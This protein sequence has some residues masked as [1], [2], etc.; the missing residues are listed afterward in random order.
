[1]K[2]SF[3][4]HTIDPE[5]IADL[6]RECATDI[7]MPLYEKGIEKADIFEKTS[8]YDIATTADRE[9]EERLKDELP[10]LYK[11]SVV[12]G[13]E[14]VHDHPETLD[15]LNSDE[16]VIWVVDPVDGTANFAKGGRHF[17][18][19]MAC[20][21]NG[22][23]QFG[24]IYDV[25]DDEMTIAERGQGA[26]RGG[27][28][29]ATQQ[30][31]KPLEDLNGF[32][33]MRHLPRKP[34][35]VQAL[36]KEETGGVGKVKTLGCAA[37]EYL[38]I[39]DN[40]MDF[41]LYTHMKPWDHL[42]GALILRESGGVLRKWDGSEYTPKDRNGG[43]IAATNEDIYRVAS[44]HFNLSGIAQDVKSLREQQKREPS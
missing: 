13:E 24:W 12:V 41:S 26:Y 22:K 29:L 4:A 23:T 42:A 5:Q 3:M 44:E 43:L 16:G 11:N 35:D 37:H 31:A 10:A 20:V 6:L 17:A 2:Q 18:L 33:S 27:R 36:I 21:V 40:D 15:L 8:A 14:S 39:A 32:V 9:V 25:L 34:L 19:M 1:M 30:N 28:Q 7:V 38:G